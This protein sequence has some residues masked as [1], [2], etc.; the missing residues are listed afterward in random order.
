MDA[1]KA[2]VAALET[3]HQVAGLEPTTDTQTK[4]WHLLASLLELSDH[5]RLDFDA[6]LGDVRDHLASENRI[7]HRDPADDTPRHPLAPG[8]PQFSIGMLRPPV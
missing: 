8:G 3:H 4:L 5:Q 2:A 7:E 1:V 6:T